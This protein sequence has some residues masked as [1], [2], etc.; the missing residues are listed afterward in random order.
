MSLMEFCSIDMGKGFSNMGG[1]SADKKSLQLRSQAHCPI[2]I[3]S[4]PI[5]G[6]VA[7]HKTNYGAAR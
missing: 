2:Q 3:T 1:G 7:I 5:I 6:Q 4:T